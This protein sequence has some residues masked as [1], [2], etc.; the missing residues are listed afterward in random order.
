[1]WFSSHFYFVLRDKKEVLDYIRS[2]SP[3]SKDV[4]KKLFES[5]KGITASVIYGQ[6]IVGV[7]QGIIVGIGFFIFGVTNALFLTLLA[8]L[9]GIFPVVGTTLV[10]LPIV[11]YFM[12]AGDGLPAIGVL[13]FGLI[14]STV[15][16]FLRPM[17]VSKRTNL[18]S[19]VVI[20]GMIGGLFMFGI[21]GLILGP[22]I[23]AYL[24]ILLEVYRK[25]AFPKILIRE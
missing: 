20:I 9:A 18:H 2:I 19:A 12:I 8:I 16:N 15:D 14:S 1:L 13:V 4:E 5:S 11:I 21:L 10:W 6:V 23:L 3:F 25:R 24:I 7:I 22:L 17:I